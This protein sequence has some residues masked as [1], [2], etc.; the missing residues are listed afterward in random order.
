MSTFAFAGVTIILIKLD[1]MS[2][3]IWVLFACAILWEVI[4]KLND[5][6]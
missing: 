1:L 2:W 3:L 5:D 6:L 4:N